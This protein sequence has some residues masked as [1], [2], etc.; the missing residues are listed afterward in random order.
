MWLNIPYLIVVLIVAIGLCGVV[1]KRNIIKIIMG[2]TIIESGVNLFLVTTGYRSGGMA[3]I[4]TSALHE[5][6]V[7][8]TPQALT[9]TSIVI[10]LAVL[11]LML[12]IAIVI[13][14]KYGTLDSRKVT[15]LKG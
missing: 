14:K 5:K 3:P 15:R 13:Y 7:L 10:G 12:S 8:P 6:M 11:A 2:V 1:F 9:L 4:Y